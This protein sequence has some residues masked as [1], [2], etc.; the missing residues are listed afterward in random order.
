MNQNILEIKNLTKEFDNFKLDNVSFHLPTGYIMGLVG[1][2]GAGKTTT[3]KL[4]L[5]L[6]EKD[7]GVIQVFGQNIIQHYDLK[8]DIAVVFDEV[9]FVEDWKISDVEAAISP[10]YINWD[11][12]IF[13]NYLKQFHLPTQQKIKALSRG[14]KMKLMLAVALSHKARLLILDEPTS[15][16]DPVARDELLDILLHYIEDEQNSVLF[17]THITSDLDKIADFL[18]ILDNGNIFFTGYKDELFEKY[19]IVKGGIDNLNQ[20]IEKYLMGIQKNSTGF[21]AL[22]DVKNMKYMNGHMVIEEATIDDILIH[23]NHMEGE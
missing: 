12:H 19:C 10:F 22:L 1:K 20:D 14:M 16:L 4:I 6:L 3:I 7:Q 9:F 2:N 23:I 5:E 8:Q 21:S 15:G 18:T 17:S 13:Q 11:T